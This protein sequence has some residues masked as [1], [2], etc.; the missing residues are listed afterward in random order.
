V[1][2]ATASAIMASTSLRLKTLAMPFHNRN[3]PIL[4]HQ[5]STP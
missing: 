5:L 1:A 3:T 4:Q 2:L